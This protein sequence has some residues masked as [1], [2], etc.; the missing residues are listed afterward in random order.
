MLLNHGEKG[1]QWDRQQ[2]NEKMKLIVISF[3]ICFLAWKT[4]RYDRVFF[5]IYNNLFICMQTERRK[6]L[7]S[8]WLWGTPRAREARCWIAV[9]ASLVTRRKFVAFTV[10][11]FFL[12]ILCLMS[13]CVV[14][15]ACPRV[16]RHACRR[17]TAKQLK[18]TIH[19]RNVLGWFKTSILLH[20]NQSIP[21]QVRM[22]K[23]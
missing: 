4:F 5:A 3:S 11:K 14:C 9:A 23:I 17:F 1:S 13:S 21:K 15:F 10:S 18:P 16:H 7:L 2:R 19:C 20:S 8:L 22:L 6:F 12:T